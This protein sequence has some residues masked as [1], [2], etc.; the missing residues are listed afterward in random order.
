MGRGWPPNSMAEWV[1]GQNF[2]FKPPTSPVKKTKLKVELSEID[3][4]G[5]EVIEISYPGRRRRSSIVRM[6]AGASTYSKKGRVIAR[7]NKSVRSASKRK[8][9]K[10]A[11]KKSSSSD[12]SDTL[13]DT[14][15]ES[16]EID[17]SDI[18]T[19]DVETSDIDS[20]DIDTSED[21]RLA[22]KS[23]SKNRTV[24][25]CKKKKVPTP[26]AEDVLP[27]PTCKCDRCVEGRKVL[28]A[29]MQFES[30]TNAADAAK[31]AENRPNT[32]AKGKQKGKKV[33]VVSDTD[34][35][36]TD[37]VTSEDDEPRVKKKQ[38]TPKKKS[39][40]KTS[41]KPAPKAAPKANKSSP[42]VQVPHKTVNKSLYKLPDVPKEKRPDLLM[43]PTAKVVQVEHAMETKYDPRPNTF[44]DNRRGIA[45]V[46]HGDKWGN[47]DGSLYGAYPKATPQPSPKTQPA[48]PPGG[49]YPPYPYPYPIPPHMADQYG[50]RPQNS[51]HGHSPANQPQM[52]NN[53]PTGPPTGGLSGMPPPMHP[54]GFDTMNSPK[55]AWNQDSPK[56]AWNQEFKAASNKGWDSP[57]K[58]NWNQ[59]FKATSNSGSKK[60]GNTWGS[61]PNKSKTQ[62]PVTSP[63]AEADPSKAQNGWAKVDSPPAL[64][65]FGSSSPV[66]PFQRSKHRSQDSLKEF[67]DCSTG[68]DSKNSGSP[69]TANGKHDTGSTASRRR[70]SP[71][72]CSTLHS[73]AF[74]DISSC[75][76]FAN[77]D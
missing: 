33:A 31:A 71:D 48:P 67:A 61:P 52:S 3:E 28:R 47:K 49:L 18:D 58:D 51:P 20:S 54:T 9:I 19:S 65:H 59:G 45:R 44:Y 35:D 77:S 17:T 62:T 42:V 6:Q 4:S 32:K 39:A 66:E 68:K 5:D 50:A 16:S 24:T 60:G 15:D 21:E 55:N 2:R 41:P 40:P 36:S 74:S 11:M 13:V 43:S 7:R 1:V 12:T 53:F 22:R 34:D 46:Y 72:N 38:K 69:K 30:K 23:K 57:Q 26:V 73:P 37:A 25:F 8:P 27:D 76:S 29:L 75:S 14:S 63:V 70:F 64:A 10:S 56:N